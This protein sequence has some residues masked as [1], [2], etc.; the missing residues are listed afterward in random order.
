MADRREVLTMLGV[1][2]AAAA[3]GVLLG[4]RLADTPGAAEALRSAT[5]TDLAGKPRKVSE[6]DGRVLVVNFW[7]TWCPP[8]REEIPALVRVREK[9]LHSGVEFVG[10]AIDQVAKVTEFARNV[11]ISYPLLLADAGGLELMRK[12]GNPSGGLPFTMVL[13]RK[14]SIAHRNLG[15]VTQQTMEDQLRPMLAA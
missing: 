4:P 1:G 9:L 3:A 7:A 2:A 12:L 13:D 6:W 11:R 15:A 10:I 8:C 5:L 14:G